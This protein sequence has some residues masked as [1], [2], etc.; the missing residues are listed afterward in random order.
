MAKNYFPKII[1]LVSCLLFVTN[2]TKAQVTYGSAGT[3]GLRLMVPTY[4]GSAIQVRRTCDNA[5]SDIGF[6]CGALNTT[7]LNRFVLASN[8]VSAISSSPAAS[9]GLRKLSCA[10]ANSPINVRRGCDNATKDIGFTAA[11]DL[12]TTALKTF[13][14]ASN[15]L[16]AISAGAAAAFSLRRLSCTY[17]ANKA[18]R[19]RRSSGGQS[20]IGF[21]ATGD[22]DTATLK[23]Y[24]GA[25]GTGYVT[26]WYDQ[27]GNGNDA[28][29]GTAGNQPEIVIAGVVNRQ[30]GLPAI[31]FSAALT[32]Y[33]TITYAATMDFSSVSTTNVVFTKTGVPTGDAAIF[34]QIYAPSNI[35]TALSWNNGTGVYSPLSYGYFPGGWQYAAL[36]ADVTT[37]TNYIISGTIQSGAANTTSINIY[38]NSTLAATT[39]NATTVGAQA[40]KDF[41]IGKR[42]DNADYAPMNCQELIVF[43]SVLSATDRQ[44]LEFGQSLYYSIVGG[45]SNITTFPASTPSAYIATWY[46]QSGN[47]RNAT[48]VTTANQ[49]RIMNAGVIDRQNGLPAIRY[50]GT[51]NMYLTVPQASLFTLADSYVIGSADVAGNAS[52]WWGAYRTGGNTGG[53]NRSLANGEAGTISGFSLWSD[54]GGYAVDSVYVNQINS[55]TTPALRNNLTSATLAQVTTR[56][57]VAVTQATYASTGITFGGDA[58]STYAALTGYLNEIVFFSAA[59]SQTDKAYVQWS[60]AQYYNISGV[61]IATMPATPPSGYIAKWYDQS[62]NGNNLLQATTANQPR[63]VNAGVINLQGS[64]PAIQL[65]GANYYMGQSTLSI[66]NPYTA[67]AVATR[68]GAAGGAS[69]GYER[70]VNIS[71]TGDSYGFM[72]SYTNLGVTNYATF[73]GN[74]AGTWND[75][76]A[77]APN[78]AVTLNAQNI[79]S[80][81]VATGATGLVPSINGTALTG[82]AGTAATATGFLIGAPY[83][84]STL[85]QLWTGNISEF[86]IFTSALNTTRRTLLETNEGAYYGLAPSNSK[87]TVASG[88]NLFVSGVGRT[89]NV[90]SV[91]DSRQS[92]GM[93][94]IVGTTATDY[95]KDNGDYITIGTTCPTGAVT[96]SL[97]MPVGATAGYERWLNDW[98]LNK[99]DI[100]NN[101]GNLQLF[102]D[103]SAYGV[104][105]APANVA[106]YQLWGRATT[107]ANF[108]VV[109][110]T[111]AVISGNRVVFTLPAANLGTTGYYTIGT[112]DYQNSPL[113]IELLSFNA[114]PDGNKVDIAWETITETNN[115][116]FTIEKSKDG[117]SFAKLMDVPGAGTCTSY[118]NYAEVD[119]TPYEG[120]SY[121]RLKQTDKN[122][123]YKYFTMVPV[124]ISANGQQPQITLYPNP[125]DNT[126]DL[127]VELTGYNK[128]EVLVVLRDIQGKEFLTKVLFSEDDNHIFMVNDTR[129]LPEGTYIIT[130]TSNDKIYNYKLIVR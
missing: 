79:L 21:T 59:L 109:P 10:Y 29:Q 44:Y 6:S 114:V 46:D 120:K 99:T 76:A 92:V 115:A 67:N 36:P 72:G 28:V 108:T 75:I 13:V 47:G 127:R 56:Q 57:K 86:T 85:N 34:D 33:L 51:S 128:K 26:K 55:N 62:G 95:L 88:Y 18:I 118:R 102:F 49:P 31:A 111:S 48:Q 5:T 63:I 35:S 54:W 45:L 61:S 90:D 41:N 106:N 2:V 74:G 101:G 65:D 105:G 16:S 70:L 7:A 43:A 126:S 27:S 119:Y 78:T 129:K 32:S 53:N 112:I 69:S 73:T 122:G 103:F 71:A 37:G 11:G 30:G 60:Q 104:A 110:T 40:S 125:I 3:Y 100:L 1:L 15:P 17:V 94:I 113:P 77:D 14:L 107:A 24:V 89:S 9:Y 93:G 39:N 12:D 130:A 64:L 42:W 66:S 123:A 58:Q 82:K 121:Y 22:L 97:N 84:I 68:T 116:Y 19:V 23:T 124:T 50:V 87:Y 96:T 38:Q 91:A 83:S 20:D 98:Y 81:V 4:T 52:S 117:I 80:M 8:P 25:G